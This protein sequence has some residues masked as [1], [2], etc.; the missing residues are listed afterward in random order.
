M[1][2]ARR[3]RYPDRFQKSWRSMMKELL[4][5]SRKMLRRWCGAAAYRRDTIKEILNDMED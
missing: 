5:K 4:Q 3:Y 1:L 2:S